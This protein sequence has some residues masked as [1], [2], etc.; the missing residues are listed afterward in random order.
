[1]RIILLRHGKPEAISDAPISAYEFRKWIQL[2]NESGIAEDSTPST[3]SI[4]CASSSNAVLCST[5]L[6]SKKSAELI[7]KSVSLNADKGLC[8]AGM[9]HA[10]WS[11]IKISPKYWSVFFRVLWY[12]GY[13][14]HSESYSEATARARGAATKLIASAKVNDSVLFVGHGIFNRLVA[15][16]LRSRGWSGPRNPGSKYWAYGVYKKSA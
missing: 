9:P 6:R 13:A 5:L 11:T 7:T 2:Y 10:E 1:V 8:E 16:E 15:K 3:E 12:L 4:A 14:N